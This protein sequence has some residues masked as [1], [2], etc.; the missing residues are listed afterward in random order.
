MPTLPEDLSHDDGIWRRVRARYGQSSG[1]RGRTGTVRGRASPI[2]QWVPMRVQRRAPI[3]AMAAAGSAGS[4][5]VAGVTGLSFKLAPR[6]SLRSH[7]VGGR[8]H[9]REG[10]V[11]GLSVV[12]SGR[13]SLL[14]SPGSLSY[15]V[16][17]PWQPE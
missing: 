7:E 2:S 16:L 6:D 12:D 17:F 5:V 9:V 8:K 14:Q 4:D 15:A 3:A 11:P 10:R 13:P 1:S